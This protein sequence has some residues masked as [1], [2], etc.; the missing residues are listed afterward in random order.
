ML[1]FLPLIVCVIHSPWHTTLSLLSC[2]A[3]NSA[4]ILSYLA[5]PVLICGV[6]GRFW[7]LVFPDPSNMQYSF[8]VTIPAPPRPPHPGSFCGS[9]LIKSEAPGA[10]VMSQPGTGGGWRPSQRSCSRWEPGADGLGAS[11]CRFMA[12][13]GQPEELVV[14]RFASSLP[15]VLS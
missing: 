1:C 6:R 15:S 13:A 3:E 7:R 4:S 12:G 2:C 11:V 8:D 5:L 14:I 9:S 10:L